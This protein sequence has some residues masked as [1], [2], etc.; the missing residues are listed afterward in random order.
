MAKPTTK[1]M[2]V[3]TTV[4]RGN[5]K[6]GEV[7]IERQYIF[8]KPAGKREWKEKTWNQFHDWMTGK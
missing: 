4:H 3:R 5:A 8:W 1:I 2:S 7:A 6:L